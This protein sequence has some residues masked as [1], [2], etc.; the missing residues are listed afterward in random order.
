MTRTVEVSAV[1][2]SVGCTCLAASCID[3]GQGQ[4]VLSEREGEM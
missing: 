2:T 1:R 4:E 3:A